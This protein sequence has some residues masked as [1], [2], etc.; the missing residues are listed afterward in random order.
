MV[1]ISDERVISVGQESLLLSSDQRIR[2]DY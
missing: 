2:E 1:A